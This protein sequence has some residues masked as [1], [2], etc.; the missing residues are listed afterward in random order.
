MKKHPK[1]EAKSHEKAS[2]REPGGLPKIIE[3]T[4]KTKI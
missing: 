2:K 1:W 3:K 4:I